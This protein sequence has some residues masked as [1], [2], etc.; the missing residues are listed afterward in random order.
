MGMVC[1][2]AYIDR[3]SVEFVLNQLLV[4]MQTQ[5]VEDIR[6]CKFYKAFVFLWG[7]IFV[8]G[9]NH[10]IK[11]DTHNTPN[12]H[13]AI[14]GF[15]NCWVYI[16]NEYTRREITN[17]ICNVCNIDSLDAITTEVAA[18]KAILTICRGIIGRTFCSWN[19]AK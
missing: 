7:K 9:G 17:Y 10:N 2:V 13:D 3:T 15:I 11:D 5:R 19:N 14:S 8:I 1:L 12:H 4:A 16:S 18:S 6:I